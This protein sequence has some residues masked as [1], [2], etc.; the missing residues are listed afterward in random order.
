MKTLRSVT[1][2]LA[3]AFAASWGCGGGGG[4]GGTGGAPGTGGVVGPP[5]TG[6]SIA[7]ATGLDAQVADVA[8]DAPMGAETGLPLDAAPAIDSGT[9]PTGRTVDCTGLLPAACHDLIINPNPATVPDTVLPQDPGP[10]PTP[11]YPACAAI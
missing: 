5:A 2:I 3:A 4:G 9:V 8:K 1:M 10:D 6:G 11:G 7:P